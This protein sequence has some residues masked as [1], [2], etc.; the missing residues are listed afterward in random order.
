MVFAFFR[1]SRPAGNSPCSVYDGLPC[2]GYTPVLSDVVPVIID[3]THRTWAMLS[4]VALAVLAGLYGW[5]CMVSTDGPR[6]GS[7]PGLAF[8]MLAAAL[9]VFAGFLAARK[10]MPRWQVGAASWWLKGHIW[11]SLLSLPVTLFHTGFRFG[12]LLAQG[13]M[14]VYLV[15]MVSGVIGLLIQQYVPRLMKVT[16]PEQAIFEQLPVVT[17]GLRETADDHVAGICGSLFA[18]PEEEVAEG[19]EPQRILRSFYLKTARPFLAEAVPEGSPLLNP[20]QSQ[21]VFAQLGEALPE[22]MLTAVQAVE[23]VIDERR[24]LISQLK[25]QRWLHGWL[26][27]HVPISIALLVLGV[28]HIV[29]AVY[30]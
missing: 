23:Q 22:Q 18:D 21:G 2:L 9:M 15:V 20:T 4:I 28:A 25:L 16:L 11:L 6:G 7:L 10:K 12:G 29:T 8:G 19:F 26:V 13:L 3:K 5:Y 1:F 24:Q 27:V 14:W 17:R 30:F